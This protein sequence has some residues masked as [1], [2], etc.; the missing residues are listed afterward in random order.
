MDLSQDGVVS[1]EE[2][3]QLCQ[4]PTIKSYMTSLDSWIQNLQKQ[5]WI[6]WLPW[7]CWSMEA[8][9]AAA[10]TQVAMDV[11]DLLGMAASQLILSKQQ[12]YVER[13]QLS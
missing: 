11:W 8:G 3:L 2:F 4:D 6:S 9:N 1:K 10:S 12:I 5:R 13:G 7:N